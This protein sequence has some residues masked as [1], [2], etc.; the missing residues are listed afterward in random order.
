MVSTGNVEELKRDKHGNPIPIMGFDRDTYPTEFFLRNATQA[1]PNAS[2][3]DLETPAI[4]RVWAWE[5]TASTGN[6]V[7]HWN[8]GV[9]RNADADDPI[10][11]FMKVD[12]LGPNQEDASLLIKLGP[13]DDESSVRFFVENPGATDNIRLRFVRLR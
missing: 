10:M 3:I 6:I 1:S 8:K 7:L 13:E 9:S 2:A 5:L 11:P 4:Y 12:G